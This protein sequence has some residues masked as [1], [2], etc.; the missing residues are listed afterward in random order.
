[1]FYTKQFFTQHKKA[2]SE[3]NNGKKSKKSEK[4]SSKDMDNESDNLTKT[5]YLFVFDENQKVKE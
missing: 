3:L 5:G 4:S 2:K 1:M